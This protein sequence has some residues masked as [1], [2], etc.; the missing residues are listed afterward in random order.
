MVKKL[1]RKCDKLNKE[2][3]VRFLFC[4]V[5]TRSLPDAINTYELEY[6]LQRLINTL[7][8]EELT[9]AAMAFFKT[10]TPIRNTE[11]HDK[12]L[13]VAIDNADS[14]DSISVG[15]LAK[16]GR[17][18]RQYTA[19]KR[20]L[21]YLDK[22]ES[23]LD[24]LSTQA[25][26]HLA[27]MGTGVNAYHPILHKILKRV[28]GNVSELRLNEMERFLLSFVMF[29]VPCGSFQDKIFEEIRSPKREKEVKRYGRCL[30]AILHYSSIQGNYAQDLINIV[31]S[32][33]FIQDN[34]G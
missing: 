6:N 27:L 18:N 23:K 29:N 32:P 19:E 5:R 14:M 31:L 24:E 16:L 17:Y 10:Q 26:L 33:T 15:S 13:T 25:L 4:L 1:F 20:I 28:E 34:Y 30:P 7:D 22:F 21:K 8:I 9:I 12:V 11:L 3:F 2:Q